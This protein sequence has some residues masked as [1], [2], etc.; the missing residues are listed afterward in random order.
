MNKKIISVFIC[1]LLI[2]MIPVAAGM[3]NYKDKIE[4]EA[5]SDT[6]SNNTY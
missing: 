3:S 1:L 5:D 4:T 6:D 2:G